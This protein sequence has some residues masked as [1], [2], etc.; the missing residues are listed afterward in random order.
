MSRRETFE[1]RGVRSIIWG[2]DRGLCSSSDKLYTFNITLWCIT[3]KV[4]RD[5][6]RRGMY[7]LSYNKFF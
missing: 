4:P 3:F 5:K 6:S 7:W 1:Q 2:P